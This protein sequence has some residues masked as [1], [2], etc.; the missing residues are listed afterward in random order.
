MFH[1]LDIFEE[2]GWDILQNVSGLECVWFSHDY[3]EVTHFREEYHKGG[4]VPLL[5]I[6]FRDYVTIEL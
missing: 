5:H 1:D 4:A 3:A 6:F 2:P